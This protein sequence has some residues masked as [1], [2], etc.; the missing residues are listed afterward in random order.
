MSIEVKLAPIFNRYTNN[1]PVTEVNGSTVGEC[2][3]QLIKQFPDLKPALLDKTGKLHRYLDVYVNGES[4]Y[5]EELAKP[6]Q[7]GDK[8]YVLMVITG[9]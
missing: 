3:D 1:Q 4:A 5:P 6:V 7:D 8:L 2:L 9:G